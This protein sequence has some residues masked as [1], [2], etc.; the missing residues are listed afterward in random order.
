MEFIS[1]FTLKSIGICVGIYWDFTLESIEIY[2][3][4]TLEFS[5]EF[6]LEFTPPESMDFTL[7]SIG[8]S[9]IYGIYL[10]FMES[11]R[12]S[13]WAEIPARGSHLDP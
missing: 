2:L 6:I 9:G 11:I 3:E 10:E 7:E 13:C 5:L 4:F 8:I 12:K 1:E